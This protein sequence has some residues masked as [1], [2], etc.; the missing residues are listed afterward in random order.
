M[1]R[2]RSALLLPRGVKEV[3]GLTYLKFNTGDAHSCF[4]F[5]FK[6]K[7]KN[8]RKK[9]ISLSFLEASRTEF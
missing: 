6:K 7:R 3:T 1:K 2:F 9:K 8:R 5:F 4:F